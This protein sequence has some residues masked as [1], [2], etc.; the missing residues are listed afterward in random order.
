M[1][2]KLF[3]LLALAY[4]GAVLANPL[5]D[6]FRASWSAQTKVFSGGLDKAGKLQ[7]VKYPDLSEKISLSKCKDVVAQIKNNYRIDPFKQKTKEGEMGFGICDALYNHYPTQEIYFQNTDQKSQLGLQGSYIL[8]QLFYGISNDLVSLLLDDKYR[9]VE[10]STL[11]YSTSRP[12]DVAGFSIGDVDQSGN[13]YYNTIYFSQRD[14]R[15]SINGPLSIAHYVP[16]DGE[17]NGVSRWTHVDSTNSQHLLIHNF[18][19]RADKAD[20]DAF[21]VPLTYGAGT[22]LYK[23]GNDMSTISNNASRLEVVTVDGQET[24][25]SGISLVSG[26]WQ[27]DLFDDRNP[28]GCS[29]NQ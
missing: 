16:V 15:T 23:Y 29:Y 21:N 5:L 14:T 8:Q 13:V 26:Q 1:K 6:T 11:M 4:S 20:W 18:Y 27:P 9:I 25:A 28:H 2:I 22:G 17:T 7:M 10:I 12:Y 19:Q 24:C 3:L